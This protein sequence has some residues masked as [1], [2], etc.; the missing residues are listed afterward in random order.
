[1]TMLELEDSFSGNLCRCTGYRP[2]LDAAKSFAVDVS[3]DISQKILDI[4]VKFVYLILMC[5]WIYIYMSY[6]YYK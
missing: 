4:E 1:M 3:A 2:I 6:V 5:V